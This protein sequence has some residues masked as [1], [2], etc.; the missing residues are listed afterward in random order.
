LHIPKI[1]RILMNFAEYSDKGKEAQMVRLLISRDGQSLALLYERYSA[2]L[3]GIIRG[4]ISD[5]ELGKEVLQDAFVKIWQ[6]AD[7]YDATKGRLFTWMVQV[8]RRLAIDSIRSKQFKTDRKTDM[9][10][11]SVSNAS[12][13]SEETNL[14]DIGLRRIVNQLDEQHK[15][16]ITLLYFQDYTQKE[17]SQE[18]DIPLGTVKTRTRKAMERLRGI[19][20]NEGLATS[21]AISLTEFIK[22]Y[23]GH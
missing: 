8:T 4:M 22:H 17:V 23:L 10:P 16:I 6:N 9:L 3:F 14:K 19:L 1:T 5:E 18:L 12:S 15:S 20:R 2:A 21:F 7:K 11:D 13:L